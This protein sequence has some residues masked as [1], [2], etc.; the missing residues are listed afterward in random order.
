[1]SFRLS[2][3]S[4]WSLKLLAQPFLARL[5]G[6]VGRLEAGATR[7]ISRASR[8]WAR[9]QLGVD[10][11]HLLAA[12]N[13][14]LAQLRVAHL[15]PAHLLLESLDERV[16]QHARKR[17]PLA[18][19]H[20]PGFGLCGDPRRFG[21]GQPAAE[22]AQTL[23]DRVLAVVER[24]HRVAVPELAQRLLGGV[25]LTLHAIDLP[26]QKGARLAGELELRLRGSAGC[27]RGCGRWR[28][29]ARGRRSDS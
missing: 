3:A 21:V 11:L 14:H 9:L 28:C 18:H 20:Q 22:V 4:C 23:D 6:E 1:M 10:L 16:R 27:S 7:S 2:I 15:E 17:V 8:P 12:G 13:E 5:S 29:A 19:R 25:E 26:L 24:D